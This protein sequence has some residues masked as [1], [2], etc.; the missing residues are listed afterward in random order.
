MAASAILSPDK[1]AQ[2]LAAYQHG[3]FAEALELIG[4]AIAESETGERW[5]DWAVAQVAVGNLADA[6]KAF[7]RALKI[8]PENLHAAANLGG[9]LAAA[10]RA[11]EAIPLLKKSFP[12]LAGEE[13]N[14]VAKLLDDCRKR[15]KLAVR[16]SLAA[17]ARGGV[18]PNRRRA[19]RN[20]P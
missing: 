9:L 20:A 6:E 12:A 5:N 4:E 18:A 2:G 1:H 15:T 8:E 19:G 10:G 7:R 13:K 17:R 14:V 11:A 16:A 3:R